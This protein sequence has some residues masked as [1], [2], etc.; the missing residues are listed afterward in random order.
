M[1][2]PLYH[3]CIHSFFLFVP[4]SNE[5]RNDVRTYAAMYDFA[6]VRDW[7]GE[8]F[9]FVL[10]NRQ[11]HQGKN[12]SFPKCFPSYHLTIR[13]FALGCNGLECY[14]FVAEMFCILLYF[15]DKK[16]Q[17]K[18]PFN[19]NHVLEKQGVW[20][21]EDDIFVKYMTN[22]ELLRLLIVGQSTHYV[23]TPHTYCCIKHVPKHTLIPH[24]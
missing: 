12:W 3:A 9:A 22:T 4:K 1:F 7:L 24:I 11:V 8:C 13:N 20:V 17:G 6:F 14:I 18:F 5:V 19:K 16:T 21:V 23:C 15:C 10:C 2:G